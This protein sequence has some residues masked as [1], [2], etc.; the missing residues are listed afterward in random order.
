MPNVNHRLQI[1]MLVGRAVSQLGR[2]QHL[3]VSVAP[4][5]RAAG[6]VGGCVQPEGVTKSRRSCGHLRDPLLPPSTT[7]R[8]DGDLQEDTGSPKG[9]TQRGAGGWAHSTHLQLTPVMGP[10]WWGWGLAPRPAP[11]AGMGCAVC[12][13]EKRGG[14]RGGVCL[15]PGV[16]LGTD[17]HCRPSSLWKPT[18]KL[19]AP[20]RALLTPKPTPVLKQRSHRAAVHPCKATGREKR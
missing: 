14:L 9:T 20:I 2:Q 19:S 4:Q 12:L 10:G 13:E 16:V 17:G 7:C 3:V 8:W 6:E 5:H 11:A 1:A 15:Q 18:E